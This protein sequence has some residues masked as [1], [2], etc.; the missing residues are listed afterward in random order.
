LK[1]L[2]TWA[3]EV[4]LSKLLKFAYLVSTSLANVFTVVMLQVMF[5]TY[6][7]HGLYI[8]IQAVLTLYAQGIFYLSDC[9][10]CI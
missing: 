8:A 9:K 2:I 4:L 3:K 6:K 5:E 1:H 10:I 7:F